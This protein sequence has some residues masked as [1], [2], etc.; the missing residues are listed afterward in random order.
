MGLS[1]QLAA[2][3]HVPYARI[4]EDPFGRQNMAG[5]NKKSRFLTASHPLFAFRI[6]AGI[7]IRRAF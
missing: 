3:N 5:D 1:I 6:D 2:G 7:M 4:T